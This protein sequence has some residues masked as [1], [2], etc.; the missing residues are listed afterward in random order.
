MDGE[1]FRRN[2]RVAIRQLD[3]AE[4][5]VGASRDVDVTPEIDE[6]LDD[7]LEEL[8]DVRETLRELRVRA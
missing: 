7:L 8:R 4:L 5:Y 2:V 6:R 3:R 1:E